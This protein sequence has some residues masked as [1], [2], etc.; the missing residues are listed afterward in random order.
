[1]C[2]CVYVYVNI[3]KHI[4]AVNAS[5]RGLLIFCPEEMKIVLNRKDTG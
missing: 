4:C 5:R 2:V 3:H 1:M